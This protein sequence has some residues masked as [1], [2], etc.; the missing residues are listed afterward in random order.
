[1]SDSPTF[2]DTNVLVYAY[3]SDAGDKHQTAKLLVT[4]L[5]QNG[6]GLISTQV[7]QEF[8]VTVTH[9]LPKPLSRQ[10]AREVVQT[11]AAWPVYRPTSG[12]VV[13][14][15]ALE[16]HHKLSFWDAMIVVAAQMSGATKLLSEDM[17]HG[18]RLG[19]VTINNPFA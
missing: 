15:A 1:M 2:I 4:E 9:K 16:E 18:R 17:Q 5:W 19:Q 6:R 10:Q 13:A 14:A 7:L 3:D 8:Y 12:D 11:Y